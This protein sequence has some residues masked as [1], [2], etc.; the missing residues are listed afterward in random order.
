LPA[1]SAQLI[2]HV[3]PATRMPACPGATA[4]VI[5]DTHYLLSKEYRQTVRVDAI[6]ACRTQWIQRLRA[7]PQH[8]QC[9]GDDKAFGCTHQDRD[10][11]TQDGG[12]E[13]VFEA[14]SARITL[15]DFGA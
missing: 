12:V 2:A 8:F 14:D 10:K 5:E 1:G 13:I 15:W 9:S 3:Q 11:G 4:N 7:E 6:G